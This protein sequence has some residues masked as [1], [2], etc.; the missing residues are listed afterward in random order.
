MGPAPMKINN[1]ISDIFVSFQSE[2]WI[3]QMGP[4]MKIINELHFCEFSK[5]NWILQTMGPPMKII[6]EDYKSKVYLFHEK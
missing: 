5:W 6:N 1:T 2:I 3:L 4:P